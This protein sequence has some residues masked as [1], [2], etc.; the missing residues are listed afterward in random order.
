MRIIFLIS[1]VVASNMWAQKHS[2]KSVKVSQEAMKAYAAKDFKKALELYKEAEKLHPG[3]PDYLYSMASCYMELGYYQEAIEPLQKVSAS[4]M[5]ISKI[6]F[7]LGKCYHASMRFDDAITSFTQYKQ[8]CLKEKNAEG[9]KE[10]DMYIRYCNNAKELV[11]S[12]VKVKIQ[13]IG[14]RVN[15]SYQEYFPVLTADELMM[16]FTSRRKV[17]ESKLVDPVDNNPYEDIYLTVRSDKKQEWSTPLKLSNVINSESH[18][19]CVALSADGQQLFIHKTVNGGDLFVSNLLGSIWSE[20]K[21][22][23]EAINTPYQ[24]SSAS[25]SANGKYLFFASDRPGGKG[26]FDIYVSKRLPS[27][28]FGAPKLLGDQVNS[29]YHEFSP[30]IHPDGKTLYFS[31]KGIGSM[32]GYDIFS[33]SVNPETGEITSAPVNVGYPINTTDDDVFFVW[34]ADGK[35]AYY[36][37]V[38][39]EGVGED[40]L[41]VLERQDSTANDAVVLKGKLFNCLNNDPVHATV[42]VTDAA[43][44][45]VIGQY[46]SNSTTGRYL[47]VL[48][49]K[50]EY[51]LSIDAP[52]F[53]FLSKNIQ[54]KDASVA[55]EIEDQ[56]CMQSINPGQTLVLRN[57]QFTTDQSTLLPESSAELMRVV[58]MLKNNTSMVISISVHRSATQ[59]ENGNIKLTEERAKTIREFLLQAGID[60]K[61]MFYKGYGSSK[62]LVPSTSEENKKLNERV[63]L[64]ILK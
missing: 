55:F 6:Q 41:Y 29:I 49:G 35:R 28:E 21:N 42:T 62:P 45:E 17:P 57:V 20:P 64:E 14:E 61:R 30:F 31:S 33:C 52:G 2:R 58:E 43:S 32:G 59:D 40:D 9:L 46:I 39:E 24:E 22:L 44:R 54:V 37:S 51:N 48:P 7:D 16:M 18:D 19:A 25:I 34:S 3:D 63:E 27:G 5:K 12:P 36:A 13:D 23:G 10:A 60:S 47:V 4:K 8:K 15:S 26:G 38:R 1:L 56:Q 11:K 50:K 53:G